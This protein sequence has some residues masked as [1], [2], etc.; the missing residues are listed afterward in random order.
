MAAHRGWHEHRKYSVA[1][2][3][4]LILTACWYTPAKEGGQENAGPDTDFRNTKPG[5]RYVGSKV[6]RGCHAGIY[7]QFLRTD[8]GHS[9]SLPSIVI[10]RGWLTTPVDIFNHKH[11][12]HYQVFARGAKVFQSEFAVDAAGKEIFRHTEQL[13]YVVGTGANGVTPIVRRGDFLF[14]AP[15][16]YYSAKKSWDLSPNYEVQDLGF[17]LPVTS[18]CI[19][20]HTG[21]TQPVP[22]REG[23]YKDPPVLE[24]TVSCENCHGPGQIHVD[25]RLAQVTLSGTLDR[26]IVNP[27][28][29]PT[30]LADNICMSCHEGDLRALQPGKTEA[31]FRPGTPLN[32]TMV[33]LKAPI[34]PDAANSPV[35]EHYYSMTL[36]VCYQQSEG[37][38]GCQ[39]CHNPHVQ[40]SSAEAPKYFRAKCLRCHTEK[41][42]PLDL[43]KR[44]AQQPADACS[45]CHM[46]KQPALTVSHSTLTDHRIIRVQGE[47]Y[48]E[49]A[50]RAT[51]TGTK[52]IYVNGIP[53][54]EPRIPLVGLLRAY[55]QELIRGHLEF[56]DDYFS[57][58]DRLSTSGNKDRFVLSAMAQKALSDGSLSQAIAYAK[59]VVDQ[60]STSSYDYLLLDSVLTRSGNLAA[61]IEVLQKGLAL[62]PYNTL[63]YQNLAARQISIGKIADGSETIRKGLEISPEDAVLRAMQEKAAGAGLVH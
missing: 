15:L 26:S 59:E 7:E 5:V 51:L 41:S 2:I 27:A 30:W 38:L 45:N 35:L 39:S 18:D 58:L 48:P 21:R 4:A 6:C 14:Q 29:I 22:G 20:C 42:C 32:D 60:G 40:P 34:D 17:S 3:L 9:T 10:D 61:A 31:D 33:I 8:M 56:R 57:L 16:S 49:R 24:I 13:Q 37:R 1:A 11:N 23:L 53:G 47:P 36:S 43:Q 63:L 12:R 52:F 54:K 50:F 28:K 25:E 62:A 19:G 46:P 55:R 44:L